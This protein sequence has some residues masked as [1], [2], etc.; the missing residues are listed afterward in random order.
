MNHEVENLMKVASKMRE[1]ITQ[2]R[3]DNRRLRDQNVK[4]RQACAKH[5]LDVGR[6]LS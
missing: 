4:L 6:I 3:E 5:G 1:M 2:E